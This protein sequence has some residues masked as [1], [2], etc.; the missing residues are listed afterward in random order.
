MAQ[1]ILVI[2]TG[3]TICMRQG[4]DGLVPE[5]GVLALALAA[6]G[7]GLDITTRRIGPLRDSAEI[8]PAEWNAILDLIDAWEGDGVLVTHGTDTMAFTGAALA[9]GLPAPR[10]P[11]I[12]CGSMQPLGAAGGDAEG[13]LV[14]A[15]EAVRSGV[16]GHYLCFAGKRM[17]AGSLVKHHS[18]QADAFR[19]AGGGGLR[20]ATAARRYGDCRVAILTV[21]PGMGLVAEALAAL[22]A[23]LDG[24]VLRVFGAGTIMQ[25]KGLLA[26]LRD[27][28]ARGCRIVA[29]SQCEQGGLEAGAY[30]AG[31]A[32]WAAGV[33]NG[34]DMTP[35]RAYCTLWLDLS[36]GKA[37]IH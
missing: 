3:G 1:R 28:V 11:V 25:D 35:E 6:M 13:N 22:L 17:D 24:A 7:A 12:L 15:L 8:G 5:D 27:A 19:A 21:A 30:A 10:A 31:A 29:V 14:L 33:V 37:A 32:I 4:E 26:V 23:G 2:E 36:A 34:D 18:H 9:A 16:P 20:G